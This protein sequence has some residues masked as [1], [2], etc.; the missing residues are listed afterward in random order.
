MKTFLI[1]FYLSS[2]CLIGGELVVFSSSQ[3]EYI[4]QLSP[5]LPASL[6][7]TNKV[8]GKKEAIVFGEALFNDWRLSRG[9]EFACATC[10]RE[11]DH[12]TTSR[13]DTHVEIPTLYN[14]AH[15]KWFFWDGRADTLWSQA[16]G[17]IEAGIEHDFSRTEIAY[18]ISTDSSY[19]D[20]YER[21][22]GPTI[23]F[24]DEVRFP[25]PAKPSS[26]NAEANKNWLSM[27][28][29]DQFKVN[30]IFANVGKILAAYQSQIV[31]PKSN[32]DVFVEGLKENSSVK[33]AAMSI[34]AKRGLKVFIGKGQCITCHS[35][36]NFSDS[37]FHDMR[38]PE[39]TEKPGMK[40]GRSGGARQVRESIFSANGPFSDAPRSSHFKALK[41]QPGD[42]YKIKTPT[43]RFIAKTPPYMHTGQFR[44]L[45]HVIEF[46]SEMKE[47][48]EPVAGITPE[49]TPKHFSEQ[50][51]K[52]LLEFLNA[53]STATK[54]P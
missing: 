20:A 35:G 44:F 38:L 13:A 30:K 22:F 36:P 52:D 2:L 3:L 45:S 51:K 40:E 18:L 46:Y 33:K 32:F 53:L 10:H 26:E 27:T 48:R 50:E 21:L 11:T 41:V 6:D 39:F 17:P 37:R 8:D 43:L 19:R 31:S 14:M 49:M 9:E 29:E 25:L 42:E 1:L 16:L 5:L 34:S 7:P 15:N 54:L 24:D 4:K 47:A 23:V 12:F 28:K